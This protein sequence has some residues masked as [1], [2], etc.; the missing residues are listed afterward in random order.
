MY[1]KNS[2]YQYA[3]SCQLEGVKL[4]EQF[5]ANPIPHAT[6]DDTSPIKPE[7]WYAKYFIIGYL[8]LFIILVSQVNFATRVHSKFGLAITGIV[9]LCCSAIM[10]LSVLAL[11]GWNG[12]GWSSLPSSV[13][14]W[15]LPMVIVIVGVENMSTLVRSPCPSVME[16]L[17]YRQKLCFQSHS[18][19][20]SLNELGSA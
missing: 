17:M 11:I 2:D 1:Q 3:V 4:I 18:I 13:P 15:V 19:I 16:I 7:T 20:L 8:A 12:W 10:S 9:Q 6:G 14:A 5:T